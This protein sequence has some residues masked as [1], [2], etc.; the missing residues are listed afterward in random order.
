MP[1]IIIEIWS[2]EK[3]ALLVEFAD[4]AQCYKWLNS[5]S[6]RKYTKIHEYFTI[7]TI[8]LSTL[9]GTASFA[10]LNFPYGAINYTPYIIGTITI[11]IGILSTI[12]Q[13]LKVTELKENYRISSILWDK[14]AR[15]IRIE[16][17][18]APVERMDAGNFMRLTRNDFDHL[19][20]TTPIISQK[21]I[22]DFKR[23]LMGTDNSDERKIY[24]ALKKPDILDR[25]VSVEVNRHQWYKTPNNEGQDNISHII[26]QEQRNS[27][28]GKPLETIIKGHEEKGKCS[29]EIDEEKG[30]LYN[31][32][33]DSDK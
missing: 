14:Y 12:Q 13:Y 32:K 8:V 2:I 20:E 5:R 22:K 30:N 23:K 19:M 9:T 3:E 1:D 33:F 24:N 18:K 16:L 4:I 25:I 29:E 15:N 6:H 21:T 10:Q 26:T 28:N 27:N 7:P 11:F 31:S 17:S